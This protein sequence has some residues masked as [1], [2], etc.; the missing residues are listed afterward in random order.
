MK[1]HAQSSKHVNVGNALQQG[2]PSS[3]VAAVNTHSEKLSGNLRVAAWLAGENVTIRKVES[4]LEAIKAV[5]SD[6]KIAA[7]LKM[8]RTKATCLIKVIGQHE[9]QELGKKL[10]A[11][12][13]YASIDESVNVAATKQLT[14]VVR[15][16]R[17]ALRVAHLCPRGRWCA[18]L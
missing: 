7:S 2:M 4:L 1:P 15:E 3:I 18:S 14:V 16:S 6:S 12:P 13:F 11:C 9:V 10:Q 5:C 8:A 17:A